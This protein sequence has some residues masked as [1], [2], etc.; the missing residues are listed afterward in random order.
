[1]MNFCDDINCFIVENNEFYVKL[2]F[3]F[4]YFIRGK[5]EILVY[6]LELLLVFIDFYYMKYSLIFEF[7]KKVLLNGFFMFE[8]RRGIV[9]NLFV[10]FVFEF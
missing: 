5:F 6:I 7:L 10:R 3:V 4:F 8:L 1:M 2:I 9:N